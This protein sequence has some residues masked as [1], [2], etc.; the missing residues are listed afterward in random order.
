MKYLLDTHIFIWS[1]NGD[2]RLKTSIKD[3]ISDK[4]NTIIVSVI[5]G[6]EMSIKMRDKRKLRLKTSIK[7]AF[8]I[9]GFDILNVS[10]EHVLHLNNLPFYHNDP[11]DRMLISQAKAENLI[12]ITHDKQIW[13]YDI[14]ILKAI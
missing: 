8:E 14:D 10:L 4:N 6:W 5:S 3:I 12:F 7:K 2:T 1:L 13:K 9:S 11:F